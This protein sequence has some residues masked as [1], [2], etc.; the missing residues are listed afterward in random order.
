MLVTNKEKR[1]KIL[2]VEDSQLTVR[3]ISDF[4]SENGY[5]IEVTASGEEAV[6]KVYNG[7]SIDLILMDIG[8]E[9]KIDGIDAARKILEYQDIPIVFITANTSKEVIVKM[10]E[11]RAYGFVLK[12]TE[13]AVMLSTIEMAL[14]LYD[15]N[16]RV[17]IKKATLS[18]IMDAT[19]DSIILFDNK[20]KITY[21]NLANEHFF[22]YS[23]DEILG[24]QLD[25]FLLSYKWIAQNNY[26]LFNL[27]ENGCLFGKNVE[28]IVQHKNGYK[29][30]VEVSLSSLKLEDVWYGVGVLRDISAR[31]QQE[32]KL[33]KSRR[34]Y[35]ELAENAPVGV[36]KCD[37]HGNITY[38]NSKVLEIM[39]SSNILATRMINLFTDPILVESGLSQILL[40]CIEKNQSAVQEVSYKTKWGKQVWLRAHIKILGD[41]DCLTGIQIIIDEITKQ[42]Q[43]EEKLHHLSV[44]DELTGAYNRRYMKEKI[45][46][47]I[48]RS[49]RSG[50]VFSIVMFDI[51]HFKKIND[52]FGHNVG[53]LILGAIVKEIKDTLNEQDVFARWGGE[54]FIILYPDTT[55]ETAIQI[56]E[57]LRNKLSSLRMPWI[58]SMTASFG[59][60]RFYPDDSIDSLV[61]RADLMMYQAKNDGR[62]CVRCID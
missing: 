48:H 17:K 14:K 54:E 35:L 58:G 59:V 12:G 40:D 42:K 45:E 30:Y 5:E 26:K 52:S 62:N 22:G 27:D 21:C 29:I 33:L 16:S 55:V 10:K 3:L 41:E 44:T 13:K 6:Y 47:E 60:T 4:L 11:V 50:D 25:K 57:E 53:D 18:A 56:A 38:L 37:L 43:L 23:R 36:L 39:G 46:V 51:D 61:K 8:L 19:E 24:Q 32:E 31:K 34:E 15:A 2:L 9:G 49:L 20:L 1:K 28:L 7:L